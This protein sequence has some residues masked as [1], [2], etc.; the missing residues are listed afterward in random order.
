MSRVDLEEALRDPCV[1]GEG[2]LSFSLSSWEKKRANHRS[3][4]RPAPIGIEPITADSS[5]YPQLWVG[6]KGD[7]EDHLDWFAD[8]W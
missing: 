5:L 8:V 1:P 2:T 6:M 3:T 7:N 4:I